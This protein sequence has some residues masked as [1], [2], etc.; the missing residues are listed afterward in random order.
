M[1]LASACGAKISTFGAQSLGNAA[2]ALAKRQIKDESL[3]CSLS[4]AV[5]G[6]RAEMKPQQLSNIV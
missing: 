1:A 5:Q 2:W 4:G 3:M 6:L